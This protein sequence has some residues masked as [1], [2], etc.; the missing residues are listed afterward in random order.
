MLGSVKSKSF[1]LLSVEPKDKAGN[2]IKDFDA[3]IIS[4]EG[5]E[6]KAWT[7]LANYLGDTEVVP[8]YYSAAHGRKAVDD[9][10]NIIDL[11][12]NPNKIMFMLIGIII[13]LIAA[14]IL[15]IK[16]IIMIY[17]RVLQKK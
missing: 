11:I 1:G 15:I 9:S 2:P 7:A 4:S 13:I 8:Q 10:K 5:K 14:I 12:K 3:E 17:K 6:I 16:V